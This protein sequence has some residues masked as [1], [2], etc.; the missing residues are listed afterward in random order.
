MSLNVGDKAPG[1]NL[2]DEQGHL[3]KLSDLQGKK[4]ILYFYP[5]DDTPGCTREACDFTEKLTAI[6]DR[7]A[8]VLG[9]SKDSEKAHQKFKEKY[10]L[11][12]PLLVDE[13]GKLC[14]A[15]GVLGEKSMFGKKY[16]GINRTTFLIDQEG[17]I[18]KIWK[19][20]KVDGHVDEILKYL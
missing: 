1:F 8:I 16:F 2:K 5:K 15:Y 12:F 19:N 4:V 17:R 3:V 9:V 6:K 18:E 11:S 7:H 14:E 10:D 20:V 13:E